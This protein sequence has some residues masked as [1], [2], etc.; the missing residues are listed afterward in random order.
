M[1]SAPWTKLAELETLSFGLL[2]FR[3][4]VIPLFA[5]STLERYDFTHLA[6]PS[7]ES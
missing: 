5:L 2:V 3:V 4:R 7:I 6:F 1:L